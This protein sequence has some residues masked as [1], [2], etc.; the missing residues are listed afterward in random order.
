MVDLVGVE[1]GRVGGVLG[2]FFNI[3]KV[4]LVG[5]LLEPKEKPIAGP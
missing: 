2:V 3:Q 4:I 5:A 1:G